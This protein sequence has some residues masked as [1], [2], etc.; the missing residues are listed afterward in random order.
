[1]HS[2]VIISAIVA[3]SAQRSSRSARRGAFEPR[4]HHRVH[5]R[6]NVAAE[7]RDLAHDRRRDEHVLL[8]RAS[9]TAF[10]PRDRAAGSS[11]P[12]G[13][14]TRSRTRRA[15]RAGRRRR[16]LLAHELQ[17]QR[18]EARHRHVAQAAPAPRA[19]SSTRSSRVEERPLRLAVRDGDDDAIEQARR[20]AH[21]VLVAPRERVERAG[22]D[23]FGMRRRL[24]AAATRGTRSPSSTFG[25]TPSQREQMVIHLPR[26]AAP[27]DRRRPPAASSGAPP[28]RRRSRSGA[29]RA[30]QAGSSQLH[31]SSANGGSRKIDVERARLAREERL[32]V[33]ARR[34]EP[35]QAEQRGVLAQRRD[36]LAGRGRRRPPARAP[37]ESASSESAPLPA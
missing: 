29:R 2:S 18:R 31:G 32:G 17:Q 14:R 21:E 22:V 37:R 20:A 35:A 30:A 33:G 15:G 26:R 3:A 10:R 11:R 23:D 27:H 9:G 5:E 36:E 13:T 34:F 24:D 6:R 16:L 4:V 19:P 12:S 28:R 8:G 1:M 25:A 7:L